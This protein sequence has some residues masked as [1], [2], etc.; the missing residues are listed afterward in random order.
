MADKQMYLIVS[1]GIA[2]ATAK[3]CTAPLD[4]IKILAQAGKGIDIRA[5]GREILQ[6]EGVRGLWAG[7]VV[8][9][10]RI[11]PNKGILFASNGRCWP[12][13]HHNA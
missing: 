10:I 12:F 8:N 6:K 2:G 9:C 4:R 7:N 11:F 1:G 3:T 5:I 13:S